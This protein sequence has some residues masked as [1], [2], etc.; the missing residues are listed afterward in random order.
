MKLFM[1]RI[2]LH[3]QQDIRNKFTVQISIAKQLHTLSVGANIAKRHYS[4]LVTEWCRRLRKARLTRGHFALN[5]TLL[6][7]MKSWLGLHECLEPPITSWD[8]FRAI[9]NVNK[10]AH[11][12]MSSKLLFVS[13]SLEH[14]PWIMWT[15]ISL[16]FLHVISSRREY[17]A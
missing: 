10:Y 13:V 4:S 12:L 15:A 6:S 7:I 1:H 11:S 16:A 17:K 2:H 3:L 14:K 9:Q 5:R 8:T